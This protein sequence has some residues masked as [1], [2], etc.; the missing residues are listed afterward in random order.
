MD[1]GV[2]DRQ[3]VFSKTHDA[4]LDRHIIT[5]VA[6]LSRSF[7]CIISSHAPTNEASA[8]R[9]VVVETTGLISNGMVA[10]ALQRSARRREEKVDDGS[11]P[12]LARR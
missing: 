9:L 3:A 1:V 4:R 12:T 11:D 7:H 5:D 10:T 2:F 6:R 8:R